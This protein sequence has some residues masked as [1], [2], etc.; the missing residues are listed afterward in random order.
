MRHALQNAFRV[1]AA[2]LGR[3]SQQDAQPFGGFMERF[4]IKRAAQGRMHQR[5]LHG[6]L[7][8]AVRAAAVFQ[9]FG[10]DQQMH[11]VFAQRFP[12][13]FSSADRDEFNLRLLAQAIHQGGKTCIILGGKDDTQHSGSAPAP[14]FASAAPATSAAALIAACA[15]PCV[16]GPLALAL[17]L[18]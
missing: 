3:Q 5:K 15:A 12:G 18:F 7:A 6:Y 1:N 13:A 4:L 9:L 10:S 16:T 2:W 17:T 11:L 14:A 8:D